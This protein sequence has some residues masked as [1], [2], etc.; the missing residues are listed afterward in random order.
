M[1]TPLLSRARITTCILINLSATPGLGSI[2]ARRMVVGI[3]QLIL[4]LIG[5]CLIVGWMFEAMAT[6]I[7]QEMNG[8]SHA[9]APDW[10]WR[11]GLI[12]FGTAWLWSLVTSINLWRQAK[13][14]SAP[15]KLSDLPKT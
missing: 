9:N 11:W 8:Q 3:F 12:F 5:F 14:E 4:S 10:M 7:S 13:L 2:F 1:N 15:P 6:T